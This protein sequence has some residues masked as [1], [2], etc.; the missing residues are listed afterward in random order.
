VCVCVC[1]LYNREKCEVTLKY[2]DLGFTYFIAVQM[3]DCHFSLKVEITDL[4]LFVP[5]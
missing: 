3:N 1:R 2:L 4:F 5:T